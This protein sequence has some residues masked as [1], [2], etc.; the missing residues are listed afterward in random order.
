MAINNLENEYNTDLKK[1]KE[2]ENYKKASTKNK[3]K[4]EEDLLNAKNDATKK[5]HNKIADAEYEQ[6][7][8]SKWVNVAQIAI[9]TAV[10]VAKAL[11]NYWLA[12]AVG[13]TGALQAGIAASTPIPPPAK[14]AQFGMNEVIDSPTNLMVG[15]GNTPE[16][17]QVTPLVDENRFGPTG[18]GV[19]NITFE[20][21]VLSD[22]FIIDEAIP[23]I[24]EAVLR[25]E[26]LG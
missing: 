22:D 18:G 20:G 10:A 19:V 3:K 15:E 23:K 4:M 24:R 12:G 14:M 9:N 26:S 1:M 6:A 16:L 25:G 17:V 2:G 5:L 13:V 21:N 7:K 8:V 11:P